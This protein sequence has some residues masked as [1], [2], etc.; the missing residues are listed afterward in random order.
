MKKEKNNEGQVNLVN[1]WLAQK[2]PKQ[3]Q[4]TQHIHNYNIKTRNINAPTQFQQNSDNSVQNQNLNYNE[5]TVKELF[6]V[7]E[8]DIASLSTDV[9][10]DFSS[11]M[12]YALNQMKKGKDIKIQLLNLGSLISN[13]GVP[14]FVNLISSGVFE[15][16]KPHLGLP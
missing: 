5:A 16:M 13:V 11:E 4:A 3:N 14:L 7:L 10:E 15:V 9:K 2:N 12:S 1:D 6:K 8:A